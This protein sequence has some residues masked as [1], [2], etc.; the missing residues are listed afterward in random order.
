MA[1]LENGDALNISMV[2]YPAIRNICVAISIITAKVI[3]AIKIH[4]PDDLIQNGKELIH[5]PF[6]VIWKT[7]KIFS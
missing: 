6:I 2:S 5:S 3:S 7:A 1:L 4:T